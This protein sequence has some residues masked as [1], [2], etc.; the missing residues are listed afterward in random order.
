MIVTN[1]LDLSWC[2]GPL[3]EAAGY[4]LDAMVVLAW[5]VW[6]DRTWTFSQVYLRQS[7]TGATYWALTGGT[8]AP[9]GSVRWYAVLRDQPYR[10]FT[11]EDLDRIHEEVMR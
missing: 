9:T 5:F 8:P 3:P 7:H 2:R 10:T 4:E 1:P 6:P 11:P